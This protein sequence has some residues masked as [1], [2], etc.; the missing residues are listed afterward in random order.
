MDELKQLEELA[1]GQPKED[2]GAWWIGMAFVLIAL[3]FPAYQAVLWLQSGIWTPLPIASAVH[4]VGW[5]VPTTD[6]VGVQKILTW[7]FDFPIFVIPAF[8]AFGCFSAWKESG[9]NW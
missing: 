2:K 3:A 8:L 1:V 5:S 6:W 7:L 9:G 4:Y